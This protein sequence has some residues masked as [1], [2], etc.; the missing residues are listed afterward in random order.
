M[1]GFPPD[2]NDFYS[3]IWIIRTPLAHTF[4]YPIRELRSGG[5]ALSRRA[6][7][8]NSTGRRRR[9]RTLLQIRADVIMIKT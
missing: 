3:V 5:A 4:I 9:R 1:H 7:E 8:R 6:T 2:P